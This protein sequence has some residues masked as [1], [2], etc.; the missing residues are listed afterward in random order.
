MIALQ[1]R[2]ETTG[3]ADG[4]TDIRLPSR[5]G[6]A[7]HLYRGISRLRCASGH[8]VVQSP[9]SLSWL[10]QHPPGATL[11]MTYEVQQNWPG[12]HPDLRTMYH[13]RIGSDHFYALGAAVFAVPWSEDGYSLVFTWNNFPPDWHVHCS[14]GPLNDTTMSVSFSSPDARWLEA[15]FTGGLGWR[16]YTTFIQERPVTLVLR[17]DRWAFSDRLVLQTLHDIVACQR[18]YWND[19]GIPF[20][21]VTLIPMAEEA[22]Y[23]TYVGTG[24]INSFVTFAAPVEGFTLDELSRLFYHELMHHW[25]G[26]EIRNGG[27]PDDMQFAWFSEGFTE[28]CA[29][30][31]PLQG[32]LVDSANFVQVVNERFF[33]GLWTLAGNNLPNSLVAERFFTEAAAHELP[34]LRGFVFAWYLDRLIEKKSNRKRSL[35]LVLR[36]LL[37]WYRHPERSISTHFDELMRVLSKETGQ[38]VR[39]LHERHIL[40]GELIPAKLLTAPAGFEIKVSPEGTPI[41][42][43]K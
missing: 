20:Y 40:R 39:H 34:Y 7:R 33:T 24:L 19:F 28:Y 42:R 22:G 38:N 15:L 10:V 29:L 27:A 23:L 5:F 26:N 36:D 12:E 25:I 41:L 13:P 32:G 17:G 31:A 2:L 43:K 8:P 18:G 3:D 11:V 6:A 4:T 14:L 21:S 30:M 1:V 35:Q 9:D 37:A 16:T